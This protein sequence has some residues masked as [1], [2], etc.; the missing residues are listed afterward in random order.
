DYTEN[1]ATTKHRTA[2]RAREDCKR[3]RGESVKFALTVPQRV[4]GEKQQY[5]QEETGS[6]FT[7]RPINESDKMANNVLENVQGM[8]I[9][10]KRS[11]GGPG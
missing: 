8:T 5:L 4:T 11:T 6:R 3:T 9:Q 2:D 1:Q 7:G 10:A